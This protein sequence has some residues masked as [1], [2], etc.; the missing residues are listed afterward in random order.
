[1]KTYKL[2]L[3]ALAVCEG[4][5]ISGSDDGTVRAWDASLGAEKW[6]LQIIGMINTRDSGVVANANVKLSVP[7]SAQVRPRFGCMS[8]LLR[9][10]GFQAALRGT[11]ITAR[12]PEA[13]SRSPG[14]QKLI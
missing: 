7:S 14:G 6:A 5:V 4:L 10:R 13:S 2:L 9:N 1:M 3:T 12:N 11:K 8:K